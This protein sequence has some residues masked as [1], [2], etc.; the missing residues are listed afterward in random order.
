VKV[1]IIVAL[2]LLALGA[3]AQRVVAPGQ[4]NTVSGTGSTLVTTTGAQTSGNCVTIDANGNHVAAGAACGGGGGGS[5]ATTPSVLKG[6]NAGGAIAATA[7]TDFQSPAI[8]NVKDYGAAGNGSTDDTIAIN[9][10]ITAASGKTLFFPDGTY[11]HQP[12]TL[13]SSIA[14]SLSPNATLRLKASST[15]TQITI[16]A[17][18]VKILGGTIDGNS[19]NN[20]SGQNGI[21]IGSGLSDIKIEGTIFLN[22][23]QSNILT[24]GATGPNTLRV[25]VR[26]CVFNGAGNHAVYFNWNTV[27]SEISN[28]IFLSGSANAIWVGN[29]STGVKV[30]H[31]LIT[32]Y[33]RMGI[34]IWGGSNG[35]KVLA[36]TV[37]NVGSASNAFG[38]SIDSSTGSVVADNTVNLSSPGIGAVGIE[39]VLS[40]NCTVGNNVVE[41]AAIGF[42]IDQSNNVSTTGN[43]VIAFTGTAGILVGSSVASKSASGNALTGNRVTISQTTGSAIGIWLQANAIGVH[44]DHNTLV[45]NIVDG[46]NTTSGVGI[47]LELDTGTVSRNQVGLNT[48]SSVQYAVNHL[49][50]ANTSQV[51]NQ[52]DGVGTKDA[53]STTNGRAARFDAYTLALDDA[54]NKTI[55]PGT[56]SNVL[57]SG[58]QIGSTSGPRF[59][60]S[61]GDGLVIP[62]SDSNT[63]FAVTNAAGN[64]N[65][66]RVTSLGRAA[67]LLPGTFAGNNTCNS[68]NSGS[69]SAISDATTTSG[70]IT[71]SGSNTVL[72]WCNGI[73]WTAISGGG[74]S[75]EVVSFSATPTFST[76]TTSSLITL[77]AS[78]TSFTLGAGSDGQ[79]KTLTFCENATGGFT[80]AGPTNVHGFFTPGTTAS[81]CS[82]QSYTYY[83]SLTAWL[84]NSVG[85]VN[86]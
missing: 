10:A 79:Q 60:N 4:V 44:V 48:I 32:G 36:N 25:I 84:A 74:T 43:R 63:A 28:S 24:L 31:N 86:Q 37:R 82:S 3:Y 80:V 29:S 77:T 11:I 72:G 30:W 23:T 19:A 41:N 38:I 15:A 47:M 73:A 81:K 51:L 13:S 62:G 78:I 68:G 8:I 9:A 59:G 34:E 45:G 17:S 69:L 56:G 20:P 1:K 71:G 7:G 75:N 66:F 27:D 54:N 50:D 40:D 39:I 22:H 70:A 33:A 52:Y 58:V 6:N 83:T 16:S 42:T 65:V 49:N 57:I 5:I 18:N 67:V 46:Q 85:V 2:V 61:G 35:A 76:S 53:G 21:F 64:A 12:L 26:N 14:F 55:Q